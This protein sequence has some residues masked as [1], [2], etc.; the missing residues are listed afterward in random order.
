MAI[1]TTKSDW[2]NMVRS[3]R[4]KQG[5]SIFG[6][7]YTAISR[8]GDIAE[9]RVAKEYSNY[10]GQAYASSLQQRA[11]LGA[12]DVGENYAKY[13]QGQLDN[14][15]EQAYQSYIGK[16]NTDVASLKENVQAN[17]DAIDTTISDQAQHFMDFKDA[18]DK[19]YRWRYDWWQ[20]N[21]NYDDAR[22][23]GMQNI[24]TTDATKKR[25][26]TE[27][28]TGDAVDT[29]Y[30]TIDG[31]EYR[32]KT[33]DELNKDMYSI[34]KNGNLILNDIGTQFY[35]ELLN[36]ATNTGNE[37]VSF[38]TYL[39][40]NNPKLLE[41]AMS[42]NPYAYAADAFGNTTNLSTAR[43]YFG[44]DSAENTYDFQRRPS[45]TEAEYDNI[46]KSDKLDT[47]LSGIDNAY[48]NGEYQNIRLDGS[49]HVA[50]HGSMKSYSIV[51]NNI[52]RAYA[53]MRELAGKYNMTNVIDQTGFEQYLDAYDALLKSTTAN[54]KEVKEATDDLYKQFKSF[55]NTV[56][57]YRTRNDEI[58]SIDGK[59]MKAKA[60]K[61]AEIRE[62][63]RKNQEI[64]F[65]Q[66]IKD[67][68][69]GLINILTTGGKG[70]DNFKI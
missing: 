67:F 64:L 60:A 46:Y 2:E 13:A 55:Y 43:G 58:T 47:Y 66:G 11:A 29:N 40:E 42:G 10:M 36:E 5:N 30:V 31:K 44:L 34:D 45:M 19:Y 37:A 1:V 15:L 20:K 17:Y 61:A 49:A 23:E 27:R 26:L 41:W 57:S 52:K 69:A 63:E 25:Y 50:S 28:A 59:D 38:E 7:M 56:K 70:V 14:A 21:S 12:Y 9:Q 16:Q 4:D 6:G 65:W 18:L 53:E 33:I 8:A 24:F 54:S 51:Y 35:S 62:G 48:N 22:G 68:W 39:K 32:L 3:G